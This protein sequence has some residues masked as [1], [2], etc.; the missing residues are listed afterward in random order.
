M[1]K[2]IPAR[3]LK[4][5]AT[6]KVANSADSYEKPTYTDYALSRVCMQPSNVTVKAKDNTDVSLRGILFVDAR[7]SVPKGIDI[8]A[9][10]A[11]ADTAGGD[12]KIVFGGDTFTVQTIDFL[13]DDIGALHHTEIGL[14]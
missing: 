4:H 14:I 11:Q 8:K 3:I 6:L 5:T 13:Y 12:L 1:L 2:S 7:L 9:Y 10:K